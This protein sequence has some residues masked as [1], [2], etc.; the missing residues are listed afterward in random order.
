[1]HTISIMHRVGVPTVLGTS[2]LAHVRTSV[3]RTWL[4]EA[5]HCLLGLVSCF[6]LCLSVYSHGASC[7]CW[8]PIQE[9]PL[10]L[11][12]RFVL[13]CSPQSCIFLPVQCLPCGPLLLDALGDLLPHFRECQFSLGLRGFLSLCRLGGDSLLIG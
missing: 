4:S 1:M 13:P 5:P 3:S 8:P 6:H 7:I 10:P 12:L 2:P 9:S 11:L